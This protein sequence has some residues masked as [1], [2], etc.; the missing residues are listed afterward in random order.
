MIYI[1]W[2]YLTVLVLSV[3]LSLG[4]AWCAAYGYLERHALARSIRHWL[5]PPHSQP[6]YGG[7]DPQRTNGPGA[8]P[9]LKLVRS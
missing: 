8:K 6:I 1:N 7:A 3:P 4:L 2:A 9:N 5:K